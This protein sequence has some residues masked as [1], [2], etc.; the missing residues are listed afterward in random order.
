MH[1]GLLTAAK[2]KAA[3]AL[4]DQAPIQIRTHPEL[5]RRAREIAERFN[6]RMDYDATYAALAEL[7]DAEFWTA[8]KVFHDAVHRELKFVRFLPD[9]ARRV[10]RRKPR[11]PRLT[12][13]S[14]K[15][16]A[17]ARCLPRHKACV[18]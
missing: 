7:S 1:D 16:F 15:S 3:Q 2:G 18:R 13:P 10:R 9:Y 11:S 4:L 14:H 6:Q 5:R 8:D 17:G 12:A